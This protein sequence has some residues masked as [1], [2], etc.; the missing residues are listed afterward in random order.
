LQVAHGSEQRFRSERLRKV[1]VR[2][3]LHG[4]RAVTLRGL[5]ADDQQRSLAVCLTAPYEGDQLEAVDVRHVDVHQEQI[6]A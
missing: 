3:E 5:G 1:S 4:P 6:E 2:A